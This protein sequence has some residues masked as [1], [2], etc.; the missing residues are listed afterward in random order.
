MPSKKK[1]S[2]EEALA[3]ARAGEPAPAVLAWSG[4]PVAPSK[5]VRHAAAVVVGGPSPDCVDRIA[6]RLARIE[7][8]Y[9]ETQPA[10]TRKRSHG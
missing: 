5:E 10:E 9:A 7:A 8:A 1:P 4:I 3:W 2:R 6:V